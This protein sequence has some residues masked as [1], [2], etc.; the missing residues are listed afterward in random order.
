M[1]RGCCARVCV[2]IGGR[3]LVGSV[4]RP[5]GSSTS[6]PSGTCAPARI[7]RACMPHGVR[8]RWA[9]GATAPC[10]G[11]TAGPRCPA[12]V[13]GGEG[14]G[15]TP[16]LPLPPCGT[17]LPRRGWARG[18]LGVWWRRR[19]N[20]GPPTPAPPCP[21]RSGSLHRHRRELGGLS[22]LQARHPGPHPHAILATTRQPPQRG[23]ARVRRGV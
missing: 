3:W 20:T 4:G 22:G 2:G 8:N 17:A 7:P 21:P 12:P 15:R 10:P 1:V 23:W 14:E 6:T 18:C 19:V 13:P 5:W 9:G 16:T 11:R